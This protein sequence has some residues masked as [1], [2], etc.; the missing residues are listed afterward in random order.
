[1]LRCA[2]KNHPR[3]RL[4]PGEQARLINSECALRESTYMTKTTLSHAAAHPLRT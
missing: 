1:M 3:K 2:K 4:T